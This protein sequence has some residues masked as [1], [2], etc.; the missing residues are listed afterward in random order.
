MGRT[1]YIVDHVHIILLLNIIYHGQYIGWNTLL[2]FCVFICFVQTRKVLNKNSKCCTL[3]TMSSL[4]YE[5]E[6][7]PTKYTRYTTK[8]CK[9]RT[10]IFGQWK[11]W[12]LRQRLIL[13][14]KDS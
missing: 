6:R 11:F 5:T 9:I 13:S 1:L 4:I 3:I 10:Q 7:S 2:P 8:K 12:I 14:V